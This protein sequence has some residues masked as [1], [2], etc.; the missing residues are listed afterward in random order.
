M[1]SGLHSK[2]IIAL[3]YYTRRRYAWLLEIADDSDEMFQDWDDWYKKR[4]KLEHD[5]IE[6][7]YTCK[8]IEVDIR[9]LITWCE[10]QEL[11]NTSATRTQFLK[12]LI[13]EKG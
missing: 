11:P 8:D 13:K 4:E 10:D 12:S 5:L 1:N 6:A 3:P 9:K 2:G 7:G